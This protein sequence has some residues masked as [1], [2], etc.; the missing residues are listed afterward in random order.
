MTKTEN[1]LQ[2]TCS[3]SRLEQSD[4]FPTETSFATNIKATTDMIRNEQKFSN[5]LA[6][7]KLF[8]QN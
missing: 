8:F 7:D 1:E 6:N 4:G 3:H 5:A 2:N